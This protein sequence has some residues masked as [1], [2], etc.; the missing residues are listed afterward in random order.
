M[1]ILKILIKKN[2]QHQSFHKAD[3]TAHRKDFR[4]T[5]MQIYNSL[6]FINNKKKDEFLHPIIFFIH[7]HS[8]NFMFYLVMTNYFFK[9]SG[10]S[11]LVKLGELSTD[12]LTG[13]V[14][15]GVELNVP[16]KKSDALNCFTSVFSSGF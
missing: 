4:G 8:V 9:K 2:C 14:D 15:E 16:A 13:V 3:K 11:I 1:L 5:K 10:I 6:H 12:L 7:Q